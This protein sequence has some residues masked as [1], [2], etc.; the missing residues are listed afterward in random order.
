MLKGRMFCDFNKGMSI[1]LFTSLS[2]LFHSFPFHI[3]LTHILDVW[4]VGQFAEA[5]ELLGVLT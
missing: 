1:V 2:L 5:E 4:Q 3:L